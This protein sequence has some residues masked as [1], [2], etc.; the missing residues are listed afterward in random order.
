MSLQSS[1]MGRNIGPGSPEEINI[2]LHKPNTTYTQSSE[3]SV[4][5]A[6]LMGDSW[7]HRTK[8]ENLL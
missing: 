1:F 8:D 7:K 4:L 6:L 3:M 5:R 2:L